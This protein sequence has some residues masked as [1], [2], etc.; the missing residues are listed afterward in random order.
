MNDLRRSWDDGDY[1]DGDICRWVRPTTPIS[2]A[3][4]SRDHSHL[5]LRRLLFSFGGP[6]RTSVAPIGLGRYHR[7]GNE[8][9][10]VAQLLV[11]TFLAISIDLTLVIK[12]FDVAFLMVRQLVTCFLVL[13]LVST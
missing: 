1:H 12:T 2:G 10:A 11:D 5:L 3:R 6:D 9:S 8:L 4:R 7:V 13:A